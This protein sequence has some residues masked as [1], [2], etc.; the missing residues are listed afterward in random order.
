MDIETNNKTTTANKVN[1]ELL[2]FERP[3]YEIKKSN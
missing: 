2:R 1:K 3:I